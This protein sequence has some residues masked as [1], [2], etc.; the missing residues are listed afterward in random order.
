MMAS[1]IVVST[2]PDTLWRVTLAAT[3]EILGCEGRRALDIPDSAR[4]GAVSASTTPLERIDQL[5]VALERA[6]GPRAGR[7][8]ALRIGRA[9]FK[10]SLQE[11]G[12]QLG[13]TGLDFRL[14]PMPE[15]VWTALEALAAF[16]YYGCH[17]PVRL[18]V[19]EDTWRWVMAYDQGGKAARQGSGAAAWGACSWLV[20][21]LQEM[22]YWVSGGRI[23]LVE[24][25]ECVALGGKTCTITIRRTPLS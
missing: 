20:G 3:E 9:C 25:T 1:D 7:G 15:R 17:Q 6:Y 10:Y 2:Y 22:V 21:L 5:Q 4:A 23:F 11:L 19:T 13:L 12:L 24:E 18:E 16:F 8:L 14:K